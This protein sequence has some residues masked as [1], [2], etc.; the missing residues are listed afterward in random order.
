L[1]EQ[2][3]FCF[4]PSNHCSKLMTGSSEDNVTL[5][6]AYGGCLLM[7]SKIFYHT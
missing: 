3:D 1:H 7:L 4:I 5:V 6:I 2:V